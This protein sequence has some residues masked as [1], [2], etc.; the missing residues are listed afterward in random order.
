MQDGKT[1]LHT[2]AREGNLDCLLALVKAGA[3]VDAKDMV[4]KHCFYFGLRVAASRLLLCVPGYSDKGLLC[5][6][7][8]CSVGMV[9][10]IVWGWG[11]VPWWVHSMAWRC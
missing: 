5:F 2:A 4:R 1:P 11:L 8:V 7:V 3:S 9:S 10:V 6:V